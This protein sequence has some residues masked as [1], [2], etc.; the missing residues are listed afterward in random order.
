MTESVNLRSLFSPNSVAVV[1]ASRDSSAVGHRILQGVLRSGFQ[2]P[3]YPVNPEAEHVASVKAYSSVQE[4]GAPVDLGVL[5]V[6]AP[7]VLEAVE[8]CRKVGVKALV[9]EVGELKELDLNPVMAL[10]PGRGCRIVDVRMAVRE[11]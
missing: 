11:A 10:E 7:V 1:G 6:A 2:G 4:I 3:V 5:A 8:D 9:E